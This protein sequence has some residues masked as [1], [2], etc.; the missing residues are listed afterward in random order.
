MRFLSNYDQ[1][2]SLWRNTIQLFH[3]HNR[4]E[5]EGPFFQSGFDYRAEV[6]ISTRPDGN[7]KNPDLVAA[8]IDSWLI[9]ELTFDNISKEAQLNSY[10]TL[11]SRDLSVH[12][13]PVIAQAPDLISSRL[14]PFNDGNYCQILVKDRLAIRNDQFLVNTTLRQRLLEARGIDLEGLPEIPITLLP[15]MREANEIREGLINI[16]MQLFKPGSPGKTS[17]EMVN[18]GLDKLSEKVGYTEKQSMKDRVTHQMDILTQNEL[19]GFLESRDGKYQ[20]TEQ[21]K[22]KSKSP[23][24]IS[25]KIHDWA[26]P[27][28]RR[29]QEYV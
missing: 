10:R 15:E 24:F 2:I 11:D 20:Q 19:R 22:E 3:K 28:Q 4:P 16:V 8:S 7:Y 27:I 21:F 25:S 5:F 29:V 1:R 14:D 6:H 9:L 17:L 12:G 18:E 23:K 13:L 26:F